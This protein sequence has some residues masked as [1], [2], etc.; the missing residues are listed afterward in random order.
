MHTDTGTMESRKVIPADAKHD[1]TVHFAAIDVDDLQRRSRIGA[2]QIAMRLRTLPPS[3]LSN[4]LSKSGG[5]HDLACVSNFGRCRQRLP[6][7]NLK[8]VAVTS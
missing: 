2:A 6:S 7:I 8:A 1:K 5:I 3:T 4:D